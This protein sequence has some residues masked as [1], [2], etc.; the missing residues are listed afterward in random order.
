MIQLLS[1]FKLAAGCGT[2]NGFLPGLYDN[3]P[4]PDGRNFKLNSLGDALNI[5]WNISRIL[6]AAAG[7]L[8]VI[9]I[10]VGAI[11]FIISTG[12]AG[13]VKKARDIITN[14][15]VG[16]LIIIAAY[17]VVTSISGGF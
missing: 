6:I 11:Y 14:A 12:D 8:A 7:A 16:L 17:A 4:C 5:V 2:K 9:F 3:I 15:V 1:L 10:L 13:R